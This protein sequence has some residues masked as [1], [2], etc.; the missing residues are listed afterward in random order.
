[1]PETERDEV[2]E[3]IR[4]R[5]ESELGADSYGL[6]ALS[7]KGALDAKVRGDAGALTQSGLPQLEQAVTD[8]FRTDKTRQFCSRTLDRLAGLLKRQQLELAISLATSD[9]SDSP[10]SCATNSSSR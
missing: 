5:L 3:F 6:F 9:G 10:R 2:I 4:Q 8:F 7:A 1:M